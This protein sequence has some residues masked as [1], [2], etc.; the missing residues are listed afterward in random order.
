MRGEALKGHLDLLLLAVIQRG[1]LHGYGVVERLRGNSDDAFT[2]PEGTIYPALHRLESSGV[3]TSRWSEIEGRRRR[4]YDLT[5]RG[6]QE[7]AR[8]KE[9]WGAFSRAVSRVLEPA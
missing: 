1:P 2:L 7:L 3:L 8:R 6:R 4:V 5:A 9:E